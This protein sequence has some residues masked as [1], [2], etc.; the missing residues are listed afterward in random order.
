MKQWKTAVLV[1]SILLVG[2]LWYYGAFSG[3]TGFAAGADGRDSDKPVVTEE[4]TASVT[5][6]LD[7]YTGEHGKAGSQTEVYPTRTVTKNGNKIVNDAGA[8]STTS[9]NLHDT[10]DSYLT[11]SSYY[12]DPV[13]DFP[14][15]DTTPVLEDN[16]YTVVATTDIVMSAY[17]D[18]GTTAL[19]ADDNDN[20]T[21]DYA[22]GSIGAGETYNYVIKIKNNVADKTWRLGAIYLGY[23]GD[24]VDDFKML[25]TY[26]G[27][28]QELRNVEWKEASLPAGVMQTSQLHYDDTNAS[29]SVG[30]KR[31]YVPTT[32]YIDMH[33]WD[34]I[35]IETSFE[36]D[37]T[38]QPTANGDTYIMVGHADY[39]C[40]PAKS[41]EVVCDWY[42]HDDDND[43][44]DI[45]VDENPETTTNGL[46]IVTTIEPQ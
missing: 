10:V 20:N 15:D 34:W 4:K 42:N 19:T 37:G 41:G 36:A 24:E 46:D 28:T 16:A 13:M 43:P 3:V 12:G 29:Q 26:D 17:Q 18:D 39:S 25:G 27:R 44:G 45:G 35:K 1:M 2:V 14:I 32:G 38:T 21:A 7:A 30:W 11:G 40:N 31:A 23:G 6:T 33:E 9:V 5:L 22:G 8:N